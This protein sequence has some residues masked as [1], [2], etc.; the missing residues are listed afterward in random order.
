[1]LPGLFILKVEELYGSSDLQ[2]LFRRLFV[3]VEINARRINVLF[4]AGGLCLEIL[5]GPS[6]E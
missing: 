3:F 2:L 4:V 1:M 5:F 6:V